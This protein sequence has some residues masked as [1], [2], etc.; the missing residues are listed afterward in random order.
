MIPTPPSLTPLISQQHS[1]HVTEKRR[2]TQ[3]RVKLCFSFQ[4][5]LRK[6]IQ[7]PSASELVHFLFGPLELVNLIPRSHWEPP[8]YFYF[9]LASGQIVQKG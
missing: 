5:K 9:T 8:F 7:N 2:H 4:A 1:H 6:H 3:V